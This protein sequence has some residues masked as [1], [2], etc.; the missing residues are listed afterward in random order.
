[1]QYNNNNSNMHVDRSV[2]VGDRRHLIDT[3]AAVMQY[4]KHYIMWERVEGII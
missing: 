2:F 4:S 1:M 3:A